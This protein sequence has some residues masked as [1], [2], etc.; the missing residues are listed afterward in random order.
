VKQKKTM[1]RLI[2]STPVAG[3]VA[4]LT[5][6]GLAACGGGGSTGSTGSSTTGSNATPTSMTG[7]VAVGGAVTGADI[8]VIDANGNNVTTTSDPSGHYSVSLSGL[9]APLL[10]IATD[11]TG[12]HPTLTSV[13]ASVP[14][15]TTAP[16]VG[17][18]TTL[19]SAVAAMLT[20]SGNPLELTGS[21]SL[22]SLVQTA[23]VTSATAKLNEALA[24]ILPANGLSAASFD[25]VGVA[26]TPN[27]TG[28]DAVIDAVQVVPAP[29]GGTQIISSASPT[30]GIP[31]ALR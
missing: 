21:G 28:A 26:F 7:T 29:T 3:A 19:T 5:A 11:P 27:Q 6:L 17:N 1:G 22:S 24:S 31:R 4:V 8:T 15:G 20:P 12:V 30:T 10:V 14:K 16:I 23:S 9:T 13:V 2:R 25:P 18:V